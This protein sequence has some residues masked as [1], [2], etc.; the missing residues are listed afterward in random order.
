MQTETGRETLSARD[1]M[2]LGRLIQMIVSDPAMRDLIR[3]NPAKAL[4]YSKIHL[5]AEA[6]S[7]FIDYAQ[8][9]AQLTEGVDP[10][11]GSFYFFLF[12][13]LAR[14]EQ[15]GGGPSPRQSQ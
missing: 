8:Y 7:A 15:P 3:T 13:A 11:A 1:S 6:R 9:A 12:F 4:S 5:S 2:E 14:A 10:V